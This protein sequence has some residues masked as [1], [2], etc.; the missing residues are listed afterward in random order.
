MA[1]RQLMEYSAARPPAFPEALSKL[2]FVAV[3]AR[4]ALRAQ[5]CPP[6]SQSQLMTATRRDS[7][8]G[9]VAR[10]AALRVSGLA[11]FATRA[12][13]QRYSLLFVHQYSRNPARACF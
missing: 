6:Q 7:C 8:A 10:F 9:S 13:A 4:R 2:R 12:P 1:E 11:R 5:W 3:G